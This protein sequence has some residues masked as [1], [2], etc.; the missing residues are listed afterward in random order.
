[1]T[2]SLS[3]VWHGTIIV[4]VSKPSILSMVDNS[5]MS[6]GFSIVKTLGRKLRRLSNG[7]VGGIADAM[8]LFKRL[9]P[10]LEMSSG[11]LLQAYVEFVK[12]WWSDK[13]LRGLEALMAV[14]DKLTFYIFSGTGDVLEP[15]DDLMGI[16]SAGF[17][18]LSTVR[19]LLRH[20]ELNTASI[21]HRP[22]QIASEIPVYI[23]DVTTRETFITR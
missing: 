11:H 23:R 4:C 20:A 15:E 3:P 19:T 12:N 16:G 9:E 21:A 18:A 5:Q 2:D 8:T 13:Y 17:F 14:A 22:A 7:V 6:M 10:K 1:M